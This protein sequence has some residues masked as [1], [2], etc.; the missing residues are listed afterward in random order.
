[1]I[2]KS[3]ELAS[4]EIEVHKYRIYISVLSAATGETGLTGGTR[5][6]LT[7]GKRIQKKKNKKS[8]D[9]SPLRKD[10]FTTQD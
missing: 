1:M 6:I 2:T 10:P 7:L 9:L 3:E 4:K 5:A 8:L